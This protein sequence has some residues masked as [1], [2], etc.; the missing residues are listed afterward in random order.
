MVDASPT[1]LQR[2]P[3]AARAGGAAGSQACR[4]VPLP[5]GSGGFVAHLALVDGVRMP[6]R[7]EVNSDRVLRERGRAAVSER[8]QALFL[9]RVRPSRRRLQ[10]VLLH[11]I[12]QR[13]ARDAEQA[14]GVRLIV[15]VVR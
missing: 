8:F 7:C 2:K 13:A 5:S 4:N 1:R 12:D 6:A 15:V 11:L 14:R 3:R 10:A 9:G